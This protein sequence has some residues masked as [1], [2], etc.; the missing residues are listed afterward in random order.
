MP[1]P[2]CACLRECAGLATVVQPGPCTQADM[3]S[4][5]PASC[6]A[7]AMPT[8][9]RSFVT[10]DNEREESSTVLEVEIK[11]Y[12]GLLRIIAWVLN[13]LDL[14]AENA[15]V[16]TDAEGI[17][18]NTFWLTS[19][20]GNKLKD[21]TAEMLA[22]QVRDYLMYCTHQSDVKAATEFTSGPITISNSEDKEHSVIHVRED[23]PS[24]GFLLEV[25]SALTGLNTQ[26]QQG[27]IQGTGN[28]ENKDTSLGCD[29]RLFKFWVK[30]ST[31]EKLNYEQASAL[32]FTLNVVLGNY[33][34]PL[35][36][37]DAALEAT[38]NTSTA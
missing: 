7:P 29:A 38:N 18:H 12:P 33:L 22:D 30:S 27:V 23:N 1:M 24:P 37:P 3:L 31:G 5:W 19:L 14:V 35:T 9:P 17:A 4:S 11:D 13:G 36:P 20:S 16:S 34:N 26:I 32:L 28:C 8:S 25:A 21:K 10:V 15:V 2:T 6:D